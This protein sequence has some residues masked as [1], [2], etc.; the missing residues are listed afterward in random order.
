ML[1]HY[2]SLT[3]E[4]Y[5]IKIKLNIDGSS[6]GNPEMCGG[7]WIIRGAKGIFISGFSNFYGIG[8]YFKAELL[9]MLDIKMCINLGYNHFHI[10][11]NSLVVSMGF[12]GRIDDVFGLSFFWD[13]SCL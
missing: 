3:I 8:S 10:E 11:S 9:A 5:L 2:F 4:A 1:L 12:L 7:D 6:R 13:L